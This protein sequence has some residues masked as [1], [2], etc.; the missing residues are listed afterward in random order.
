MWSSFALDNL[1][2]TLEKRCNGLWADGSW[3]WGWVRRDTR[4]PGEYTH[5]Y[6]HAHTLRK[7]YWQNFQ[8]KKWD[9]YLLKKSS[10][11]EVF[12]SI[13]S[14]MIYLHILGD[15][16]GFVRKQ[17]KMR[18]SCLFITICWA[19]AFNEALGG[20]IKGVA[21]VII[22]NKMNTKSANWLMLSLSF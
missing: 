17:V 19:I 22:G 10:F 4:R 7:W 18:N 11:H 21:C 9:E 16:F 20:Y 14:H 15:I 12:G 5:T 6:T 8:M 2:R 3:R 13:H 1:S